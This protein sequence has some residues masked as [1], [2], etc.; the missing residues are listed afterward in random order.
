VVLSTYS[1]Y[2]FFNWG[3]NSYSWYNILS[4]L[5]W[6]LIAS[7]LIAN[8]SINLYLLERFYPARQPGK[9]LRIAS[10]I[11]FIVSLLL[12]ILLLIGVAAIFIEVTTT[13]TT[14][15][16]QQKLI[17]NLVLA[18]FSAIPLTGCYVLWNQVSLRKA[19]RRNYE[20]SLNNFLD[21]DQG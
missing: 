21:S 10:I 18:V 14:F 17:R 8:S 1:L 2:Q 16:F 20:A 9:K 13:K 5:A 11:L 12:V 4:G 19:I 6:V 7:T 3:G 15:S